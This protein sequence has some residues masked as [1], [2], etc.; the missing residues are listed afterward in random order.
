MSLLLFSLIVYMKLM[1]NTGLM[2][3]RVSQSSALN[4][5]TQSSEFLYQLSEI[6]TN[7][8]FNITVRGFE[9]GFKLILSKGIF[10]A[11]YL[12]AIFAVCIIFGRF[13]AGY[14]IKSPSGKMALLQIAAGII[15]FFS[16]FAPNLIVSPVW[17]TYRTMFI[18]LIGIYLILDI[19]FSKI[20]RKSVQT[21]LLTSLLF[22]FIV[23]GINEYDTYKRNSEL[24][25]ALVKRVCSAL[26]EE[27]LNGTGEAVVLLDKVPQTEQV[28]FYKDHVKSVFYSDWSLTGAVREELDN[29]RIKKV[30]PVFPDMTAYYSDCFIIDMRTH[31]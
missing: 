8:V 12:F 17:I 11:V 22:I 27:V 5:F 30:T 20:A 18:P 2:G 4:V 13:N 28:S 9:S 6:I 1:Q 23:S 31:D 26:P 10:G 29:L 24:D 19:I 25:N 21:I 15:L 14:N 7:G 16:P 3:S